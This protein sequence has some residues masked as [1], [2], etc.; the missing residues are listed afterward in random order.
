MI[1]SRNCGVLV[2]RFKAASKDC[3]KLRGW[4]RALTLYCRNKEQ[5]TGTPAF[6]FRAAV[7]MVI[8]KM[9]LNANLVD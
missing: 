8:T 1:P 5:E 6:R 4:K 7:K 3:D 9:G 2:K